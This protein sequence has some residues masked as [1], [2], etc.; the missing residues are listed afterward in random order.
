MSLPLTIKTQ[1]KNIR[2]EAKK[3]GYS[4][5]TIE[6]YQFIWNSFIKW[7]NEEDFVYTSEDYNKFLFEYYNF[8][9]NTYT[10]KSKSHFQQLMRSKR[11]LED[12]ETYKIYMNKRI[13]PKALYS[14]YPDNWNNILDNF[15]VYCREVKGNTENTIKFKNNYLI[16]ILSYFYQNNIVNINNID[17]NI[18]VKFI[19]ET[20]EK[21]NISKRKNFYVL[22]EFLVYLFIENILLED[23]S[24]YIPK[25]KSQK[26]KKI[27]TY[28][29]INEIDFLLESIPKIRKVDIRN[30]AI[31]LLGARLGLRISDILNIKLKNI[32]WI[33]KKITI[34]QSKNNN[35][36]ILP[37]SN[38]V[39][40]AII[41][42]IKKARP[43]CNNEYLF[44]NHKYPFKKM[45]QF[46]YF[47][48]Y[49]DK[50]N[51]EVGEENKKGIHNLRHSLATNMLN[52][53]IPLNII[54]STL[55]D[56]VETVSSTYLKVDLHNLKKCG[57]EVEQ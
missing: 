47:N 52:Y 42:Y 25:I 8:D 10:S 11:I 33:N 13:L 31:I 2:E 7:K 21:G 56:T 20:I 41:D 43:K 46:S 26:R 19:N 1:T 54:A 4:D 14:I 57:L 50:A 53:D 39:G 15:L 27:P 40:W 29:K 32:D 55:G 37:L 38:E 22:R 51:I 6:G 44:I 49:F 28:L 9:V 3:L 36:N 48:K 12:F 16:K 34:I 17:K 5:K 35:L 23:L 24:I 18:I 45:S 30:Y